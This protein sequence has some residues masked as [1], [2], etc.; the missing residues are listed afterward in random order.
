MPRS[1]GISETGLEANERSGSIS[2]RI[3]GG[4]SA[5]RDRIES[6]IRQG[7]QFFKVNKTVTHVSV[8]RPYYLDL[9]LTPVSESV[10]KIVQF[11]EQ[12]E[13]CNRSKVMEALPL[14][15]KSSDGNEGS[16]GNA[17]ADNKDDGSVAPSAPET[18]ELLPAMQRNRFLP[19][20]PPK[21]PF[22]RK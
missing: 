12:T 4:S 13:D 9:D 5:T 7:L 8:S 17:T 20:N 16:A 21:K 11:I 22:L 15:R 14:L 10:Q 2:R 19:P 3:N 18:P 1:P 6:S